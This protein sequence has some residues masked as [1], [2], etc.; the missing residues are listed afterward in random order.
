[1]K[2]GV[3]KTIMKR[4]KYARDYENDCITLCDD[5]DELKTSFDSEIILS[6]LEDA[7]TIV[8]KLNFYHLLTERLIEHLKYMEWTEQDIE[9][10]IESVRL[11]LE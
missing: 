10:E 4:Y 2:D 11:D 6:P 7:I 8:D 3:T 9:N 5:E 1:M